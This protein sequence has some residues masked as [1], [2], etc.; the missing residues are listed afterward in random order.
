MDALS[1]FPKS[2]FLTGTLEFSINKEK[3]GWFET[4]VLS[5]GGLALYPAIAAIAIISQIYL[6]LNSLYHHL[7]INKHSKKTPHSETILIAFRNH[8]LKKLEARETSIPES[9][10]EM[11]SSDVEALKSE[12]EELQPDSFYESLA[13]GK[14]ERKLSPIVLLDRIQAEKNAYSDISS[15]LKKRHEFA[16]LR[17]RFAIQVNIHY[18]KNLCKILLPGIG[19]YW[20]ASSKETT[21]EYFNKSSNLQLVEKYNEML[22]ETPWLKPY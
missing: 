9:V 19:L 3:L 8:R 15:T 6:A 7:K 10:R 12:Y 20:L 11:M 4:S 22:R 21:R 2:N 5:V 14:L 17:H 1:C 16:K 13:K 18:I